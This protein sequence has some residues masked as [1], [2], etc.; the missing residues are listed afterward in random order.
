[1]IRHP[2]GTTSSK[3]NVFKIIAIGIPEKKLQRKLIVT[4]KL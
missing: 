3:C 4:P 1:L 2:G